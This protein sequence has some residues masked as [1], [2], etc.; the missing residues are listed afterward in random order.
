M[1]EQPVSGRGEVL[2]A[3]LAGGRS[4]RFGSDKGLAEIAGVRLARRV[5]YA[6]AAEAGRRTPKKIA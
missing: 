5:D 6:P 4:S 1:T 3:V 2:G